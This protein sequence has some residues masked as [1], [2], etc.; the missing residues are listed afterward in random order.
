MF[1]KK[2]G[3]PRVKR[4]LDTLG[5]KYRVDDDGDFRVLFD[6]GSGRSQLA[7]INSNTYTLDSIEMR[8][9][10]S[11][12]HVGD[13]LLSQS[14]ANEVLIENSQ[15]KVGAWGLVRQS[16]GRNYALTFYVTLAADTDPNALMAGLRAT[17]STADQMERKLT[18]RDA[19]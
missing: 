19:F 5:I 14:V 4:V 2:S 18:G 17:L 13:G 8:Q 10:W 12:A 11:V 16:D 3:D 15:L 9:I 7:F 1:G 6:V